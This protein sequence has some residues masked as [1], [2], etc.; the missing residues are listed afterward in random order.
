[1]TPPRSKKTAKKDASSKKDASK[2]TASRKQS[3][4]AESPDVQAALE[5]SGDGQVGTA[6]ISGTTFDARAVEYTDLDGVA[7][8][9]G[10]IIL[11]TVEALTAAA[12][13][14]RE[15]ARDASVGL[16]R[17]VRPGSIVSDVDVPPELPEGAVIIPGAGFRWPGGR[18]PFEIDAS[19]TQTARMKR[20]RFDAASF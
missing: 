1:M 5:L 11:G 13:A 9:E 3:E 10:D 6:L 19:L 12:E 8:F 18:V 20:P 14:L 15:G 17:G 7:Y 2:K 16:H 4:P